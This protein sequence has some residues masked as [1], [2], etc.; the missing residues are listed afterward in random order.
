V[1]ISEYHKALISLIEEEGSDLIENLQLE[2]MFVDLKA[3]IE[4]ETSESTASKITRGILKRSGAKNPF[5]LDS[6]DFNETAERYYRDE[7]RIQHLKEG[8]EYFNKDLAELCNHLKENEGL[9]E[10]LAEIFPSMELE[11]FLQ[12][13]QKAMIEETAVADDLQKLIHLFL[14]TEQ[15]DYLSG[16]NS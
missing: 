3:R 5:D 9:R 6:S 16:N 13:Q 1:I 10:L 2:D 15:K 14:L 4:E 7:L 11:H 8:F 12:K